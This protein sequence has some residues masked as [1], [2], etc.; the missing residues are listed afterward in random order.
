M[1]EGY[2]RR[3][4]VSLVA[5]SATAWVS[6]P[7]SGL[8][9]GSLP[10]NDPSDEILF[11]SAAKLGKLIRDK[12][13]SA[14]EAVRAYI[15]R[16]EAVN[17]K[18][19]AV[20]QTCFDRAL[21]EAQAAD[22][23]LARGK[24]RGA[25]HGVPMT[26]KD[27]IDTEGV[28]STG[29][30]VGR[31]NHVPEK[32]AT[33]VARLRAAGAIL[34]GKT[35]TPEFTLAGGGIP[36]VSTT[37]N[38]IYGVSRN[39]YDVSRSTAGSS[40]GAGAIVSAGGA[41]FDIGSDWGGSIRGPAH[42]NGIAGI[43]PTSGRVPRTGHIVDYGGVFDSWQQL[44]PMARR[45]EDLTLILPIISG[46]DFRDAAIVP[47]PWNDPAQVGV[48]SLRVAFYTH[49]TVAETTEETKETVKNAASLLSEIGASV[50]EDFP[51]D[52]VLEL[53]EVRSK[54]IRGDSWSGLKRLADKWGTKAISPTITNRLNGDMVSSAEYTELLEKQDRS[55]SRMLSWMKSYDILLT[56]VSGKPAAPINFGDNPAA[57]R[58]GSSYTGIHNTTGWPAAV[59][60]AG[61]SPEGLPI[62]VQVIGQPW[63]EDKVL[64][65]CQY[66]ESR[67]G[68]WK[69][70][71]I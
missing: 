38:I 3:R 64:A 69:K 66:L 54:L 26:I 20:V 61:T 70:P 36:G 44:G 37:A 32:D 40:G 56:P 8:L 9:A 29:G 16:I 11:M 50:K 18:L 58:P 4:F 71:P 2:S 60:R 45:V 52:I 30:T 1:A 28:I 43:K 17:P 65:V 63:A 19:N 68:G 35:N 53:E 10:S 49:N 31:M 12:K 5:A 34:L 15:A 51:K 46:P 57:S 42:N 27:S 24:V 47:M 13:L 22:A 55:R 21:R 6:R 41:A 67:T 14:A 62:G 48:K 25:L 39:P 23:E 7:T 33:V 59:V